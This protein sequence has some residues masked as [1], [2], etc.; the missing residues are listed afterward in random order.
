MKMGDIMSNVKK[1]K[2]ILQVKYP[3]ITS[4]TSDAHMLA[5]LSNYSY[6]EGWIF[7]NFVNLWGEEPSYDNHFSMLRFHSWSIRRV[8]PYFKINYFDKAF[9]DSDIVEFIISKIDS[10]HYVTIKYDQYYIPNSI[11]YNEYHSEHEMLIYGYDRLKEM[12]LVADFFK[13]GKYSFETTPFNCVESAIVSVL[14]LEI[15]SCN[16][17]EFYDANYK[18]NNYFLYNSLNNFL[19]SLNTAAEGENVIIADY[20]LEPIQQGRYIFGI[21]TYGL[22]KQTLSKV[23]HNEMEFNDIRPLHVISDHKLMMC[24]RLK[25]L[26]NAGVI[27]ANDYII[28]EYLTIKNISLTNRNLYLKFLITKENSLIN[29]IINNLDK[30]ESLE[31]KAVTYLVNKLSVNTRV[32]ISRY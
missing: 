24:E 8:C 30:M 22:L 6:T 14:D 1:E 25:Y 16:E 17:L 2:V 28:D 13:D 32:G 29:K 12:F 19:Y 11:N 4:Y 3:I 31:S 20:E 23:L 7:N 5:I 18:F 21:K 15:F 10:G 27:E 9:F 26:A